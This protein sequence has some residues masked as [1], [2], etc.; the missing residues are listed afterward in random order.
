MTFNAANLEK[1][2]DGVYENVIKEVEE[3]Q[4]AIEGRAAR[5]GFDVEDIEVK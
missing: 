4:R 2:L 5:L 3:N 1:Q